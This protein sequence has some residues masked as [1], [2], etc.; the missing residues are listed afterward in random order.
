[1]HSQLHSSEV[2]KIFTLRLLNHV[3]L[4]RNKTIEY[5]EIPRV[6]ENQTNCYYARSHNC[7]KRLLAS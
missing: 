5:T 7:E 3:R 4:K 6:G 2:G 1:M